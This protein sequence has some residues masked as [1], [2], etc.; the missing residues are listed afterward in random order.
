[1]RRIILFSLIIL[2]LIFI[3]TSC[4]KRKAP[5]DLI[6]YINK[7]KK[8]GISEVGEFQVK[9]VAYILSGATQL[10]FRY[11]SLA[12]SYLPMYVSTVCPNPEVDTKEEAEKKQIRLNLSDKI[13]EELK[14]FADMDS[15]GF[16]STEEASRFRNIIEFGF[17]VNQLISE[18]KISLN[19]IAAASRKDTTTARKDIEEYLNLARKIRE[20]GIPGIPIFS[21]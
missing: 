5:E 17:L 15:S 20:N 19:M 16:V 7:V 10:T 11:D 3:Y 12:C 21:F 9:A 2:L 13:S 1:M 14:E 4:S 6:S 18:K 8:G